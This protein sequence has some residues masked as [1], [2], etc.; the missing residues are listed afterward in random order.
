VGLLLQVRQV[1]LVDD[2]AELVCDLGVLLAV[3]SPSLTE[4]RLMLPNANRSGS[5][6]EVADA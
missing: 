1:Q 6:F 3:S 5:F 4:I 2:A